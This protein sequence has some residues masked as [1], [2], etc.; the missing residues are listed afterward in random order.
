MSAASKK[1][2]A[3]KTAD[4]YRK[5][6]GTTDSERRLQEEVDVTRFDT[7][8]LVTGEDLSQEGNIVSYDQTMWFIPDAGDVVASQV[9]GMILAPFY[10]DDQIAEYL[11][12]LVEG[13][14]DFE[15]VTKAEVPQFSDTSVK[16]EENGDD[17]GGLGIMIFV[18]IAAGVFLCCVCAGFISLRRKDA[19]AHGVDQDYDPENDVDVHHDHHHGLPEQP[20]ESKY[21]DG[22][23]DRSRSSESFSR[24]FVAQP[25][26]F[27][28]EMGG[29]GPT[30]GFGK[31]FDHPEKRSFSARRDDD[32]L[33]DFGLGMANDDHIG[34]GLKRQDSYE[35]GYSDDSSHSGEVQSGDGS[36]YGNEADDGDESGSQSGSDSEEEDGS[37]GGGEYSSDDDIG[38][39]A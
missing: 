22:P 29:A 5:I 26:I 10:R 20:Q 32:H 7:R 1:A 31:D 14:N 27:E 15:N 8:V 11:K 37:F 35:S 9:R 2:F 19:A 36:S 17:S 30:S 6:Y 4:F 28:D 25:E 13:H 12:M 23:V 24:D 33:D 34:G 21:F 38:R 18:Y 16:E 3:F 39:F